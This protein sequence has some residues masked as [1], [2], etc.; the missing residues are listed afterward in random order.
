MPVSFEKIK[1]ATRVHHPFKGFCLDEIP[2]EIRYD[3]LTGQTS[4]VFD[5]PYRPVPRPDFDGLIQNSKGPNCP[6]CPESL[7]KATPCFPEEV[8]PE[9]RIR[10]GDAWL[11]PNL[12][13]L[14]LY[15]AVCIFG[16]KHFIG[17]GEFTSD[18]IRDGFTAARTF[19][20]TI[21]RRDPGIRFFNLNWNYMPPSGSSM[22]HPHIQVNCGE[23][24]T[25][26]IRLQMESSQ[27][28]WLQSRRTFWED[29]LRAEKELDERFIAEI[30]PTFWT[31]SFAPH[32]A[33]PDIWCIFRDC[34][35]LVAWD[36][37]E[38]DAFLDGLT[39]ALGYLDQA[40]FYSFNVSI[41]SGRGT[42]HHRVN[43]RITPRMLLREIGNSDQTYYQVL[44]RE[45]C[46][47]RPPESLRADVRKAFEGALRRHENIPT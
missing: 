38:R 41:F 40:G 6:F 1:G 29:Y 14:D 7:E 43:A 47:V 24:P 34:R 25:Y 26:Q 46:S 10:Q 37:T 2:F 17:P 27:A 42:D 28:Y 15:A 33:F 35:S 3:P 44:H 4:R 20:Q 32:G 22:I 30:G 18:I 8:I 23:I 19:I 39:A 16:K 12:L 21:A 36:D 31:L 11:F 5:L 13:P 45:P 9:G